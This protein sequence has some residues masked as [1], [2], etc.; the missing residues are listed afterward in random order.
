M[1]IIVPRGLALAETMLRTAGGQN[2]SFPSFALFTCALLLALCILPAGAPIAISFLVQD[3]TALARAPGQGIPDWLRFHLLFLAIG[4]AS[5][6]VAERIFISAKRVTV[7]IATIIVFTFFSLAVALGASQW[8]EGWSD[9]HLLGLGVGSACVLYLLFCTCRTM[10]QLILYSSSSPV[11]ALKSFLYGL[12]GGVVLAGT[13]AYT[14]AIEG[15]E[16]AKLDDVHSFY[17]LAV[18]AIA[19]VGLFS[20]RPPAR[21]RLMAGISLTAFAGLLLYSWPLPFLRHARMECDWDYEKP[22]HVLFGFEGSPWTWEGGYYLSNW[23]GAPA[24]LGEL[25]LTYIT[26]PLVG[27]S[28]AD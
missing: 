10:L 6:M 23:A 14:A 26:Q 16:L 1:S 22:H 18:P 2:G 12:L 8:F 19:G 24:A 11:Y 20:P 17:I 3:A 9:L 25:T 28:C 13:S 4:I 21:S 15:A 5:A 7:R 27:L